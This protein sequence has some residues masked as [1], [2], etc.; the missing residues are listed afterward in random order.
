MPFLPGQVWIVVR[1]FTDENEQEPYAARMIN[2]AHIS[3]IAEPSEGIV[4]FTMSNGEKILSGETLDYVQHLL[5]DTDETVA[6]IEVLCE[7]RTFTVEPP[8]LEVG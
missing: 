5:Q 8:P 1:A 2:S 7:G 6:R 4:E 3:S